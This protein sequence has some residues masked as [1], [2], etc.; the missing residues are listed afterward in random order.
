MIIL[1]TCVL[2]KQGPNSP[3]WEWS[4][5]LRQDGTRRVALPEMVLFELLA[6]REREYE[7]ALSKAREAHKALWALDFDPDDAGARWAAPVT[8]AQHVKQWE[9]LYRRTFEILPL[10]PE[11]AREGLRREAY[12]VPPAKAI[13]NGKSAT[14]SR[15]AAIW[16]TVLEQARALPEQGVVFVSGNANDFG[17]NGTLLPSLAQEVTRAGT[18]VEYLTDLNEVLA[19]FARKDTLPD[20]DPRLTAR[21]GHPS[22]LEWLRHHVLSELAP[23]RFE[24]YVVDFDDHEAPMSAW[25]DFRT[26]LAAPA[27]RVLAWRDAATY[28]MG[29]DSAVAV[30][31]RI[32][33][34]GVAHRLDSLWGDTQA[35]TAF[36]TDVRLLFGTDSLT[37]L[38]ATPGRPFTDDEIDDAGTIVSTMLDGLPG[39]TDFPPR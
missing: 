10:T 2:T 17:P 18:T 35:I 12:R 3:F 19:E 6:Q 13:N 7:G 1:D 33:V 4:H 16:M 11:A 37:A 39:R 26:W 32:V 28:A 31:V 30:T 29:D 15:D 21:I 36:T 24:G 27:V 23:D 14:G 38:S 8:P 9:T 25:R 34:A 22:T 5:A 20:D